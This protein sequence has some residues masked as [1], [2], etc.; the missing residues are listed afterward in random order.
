MREVSGA[1]VGPTLQRE[2]YM[3]ACSRDR[4]RSWPYIKA[5]VG[6]TWDK[7]DHSHYGQK[8]DAPARNVT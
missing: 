2:L 7:P 4:F 6:P 8:A 3:G 5:V 1:A